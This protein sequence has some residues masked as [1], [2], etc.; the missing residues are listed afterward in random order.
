[1][2]SEVECCSLLYIL[3][4]LLPLQSQGLDGRRWRKSES[5]EQHLRAPR[6]LPVV[7]HGMH[8]ERRDGN[9]HLPQTMKL[10]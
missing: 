9:K 7:L 8:V 1:M 5:R 10:K 2:C 6:L 3:L 4:W